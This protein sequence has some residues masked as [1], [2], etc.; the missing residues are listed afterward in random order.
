[1][2]AAETKTWLVCYDIRAPRRLRRVHRLLRKRGA[3]LQYSA[4]LVH[5]DDARLQGLLAPLR[6]EIDAHEDDLRA[7]HLPTRCK[8]WT[9]GAQDLPDGIEVDAETASALL[10]E[11]SARALHAPADLSPA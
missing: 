4:F 5:V 8:V 10:L 11:S 3:T 1:M 7:Y 9:V 2:S 6:R